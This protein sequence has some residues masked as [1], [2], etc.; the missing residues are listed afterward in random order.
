[1]YMALAAAGAK[2][3]P[4]LLARVELATL[5]LKG[6]GSVRHK[7][8][9]TELKKFRAMMRYSKACHANFVLYKE[10]LYVNPNNITLSHV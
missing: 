1:M 5:G 8:V 3:K 9:T 7:Q 6:R 10:I 2:E 4:S